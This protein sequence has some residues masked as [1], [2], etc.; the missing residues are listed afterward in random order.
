M[1]AEVIEG[2]NVGAAVGIHGDSVAGVG[3]QLLGGVSCGRM[4]HPYLKGRIPKGTTAVRHPYI[5]VHAQIVNLAASDLL[6]N[7]EP[8]GIG[9]H[10]EGA[11]L[12]GG[13]PRTLCRH[14]LADLGARFPWHHREPHH[15]N[16][17]EYSDHRFHCAPPSS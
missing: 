3:Q 8:G 13:T 10:V 11:D 14:I 17:P 16:K 5:Q 12:I 1:Q 7:V 15:A 6:E 4:R 2:V 9:H